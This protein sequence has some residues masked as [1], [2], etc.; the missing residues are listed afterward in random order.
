MILGVAGRNAV[1]LEFSAAGNN[2]VLVKV[3]NPGWS[4]KKKSSFLESAPRR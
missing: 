1:T 2:K 3:D 4:Q